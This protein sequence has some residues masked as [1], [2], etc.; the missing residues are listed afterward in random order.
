[1]LALAVI[2]NAEAAQNWFKLGTVGKDTFYVDLVSAR[3]LKD[4]GVVFWLKMTRDHS[5]EQP[6][7]HS[8]GFINPELSHIRSA[9]DAPSAYIMDGHVLYKADGSIFQA[10][11]YE[12]QS[13]LIPGSTMEAI[14]NK[15]CAAGSKEK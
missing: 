5:N 2:G 6:D 14:I 7:P 11:S 13:V 1:M 3:R 10:D 8:L 9:C 12:R 4:G 15:M